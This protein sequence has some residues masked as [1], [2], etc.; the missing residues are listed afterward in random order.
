MV[1]VRSSRESIDGLSE[2]MVVGVQ[3]VLSRMR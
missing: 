3:G 1:G 2:I